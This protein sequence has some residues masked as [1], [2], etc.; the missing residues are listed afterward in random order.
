MHAQRAGPSS[1]DLAAEANTLLTGL[2]II[3]IQIFPIALPLLLLVIAPLALVAIVGVL[4]AIPFVL[5]L[6]LAR[7]VLRSRSR[8]RGA[9]GSPG[10]A[11]HAVLAG[12][13]IRTTA[14]RESAA[15][16]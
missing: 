1:A 10:K 16:R 15:A 7:L 8:R 9:A 11:A 14:A 12:D 13:E 4:L 3:T 2:G 5:P 6:W